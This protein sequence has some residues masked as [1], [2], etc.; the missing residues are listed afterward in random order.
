MAFPEGAIMR[1]IITNTYIV[2]FLAILILGP[3]ILLHGYR[4]WWTVLFY[5]TLAA[6]CIGGSISH[7]LDGRHHKTS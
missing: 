4:Q 3:L 5:A 7:Y 1:T 2:V 6:G